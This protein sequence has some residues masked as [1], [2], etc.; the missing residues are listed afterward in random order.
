MKGMIQ[1]MKRIAVYILVLVLIIFLIPVIFTKKLQDISANPKNEEEIP[2]T[3]QTSDTNEIKEIV[4][5][6]DYK[7]YTTVKLLHR[8]GSG[9]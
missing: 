7:D 5:N 1:F 4:N 2:A 6:Y 8:N 9:I 3:Q